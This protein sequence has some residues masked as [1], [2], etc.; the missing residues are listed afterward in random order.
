[1]KRVSL[2]LSLLLILSPF[3]LTTAEVQ[4]PNVVVE[5][6]P[7]LELFAIVYI[8]AFNGS[9]D[10]IIAPQEYIDAVLTY[11]APYKNH[12]AVYL[13]RETFPRELP[14]YIRDYSIIEWAAK[15]VIMP[16]L[17]NESEDDPLLSGLLKALV[18][19]AKESNFMRFYNSHVRE[20]KNA[21]RPA[22]EALKPKF[23]EK[24]DNL[25]GH[26]YDEYHISLSYSIWIHPGFARKEREVYYVGSVID[27]EDSGFSYTWIAVH[28]FSHGYIN[29]MVK[30]YAHEFSKVDYYFRYVKTSLA[31]AQYDRHF[32]ANEGY[33]SE[34]LVE[35]TAHYVIKNEYPENSKWGILKDHAL[36][37]YL[38][39]DLMREL[40]NFEETR[41]SNETFEEYI[42][43]LIEHMQRWATPENVSKYFWEKTPITS[44][45]ALDKSY[46]MGKLILVYSTNNPDESGNEYDKETAL[47]LKERLKKLTFW[48]FYSTKPV[49]VAKSDKELTD[50]DLKQNLIIIGGPGANEIA[51]KLNN[52]LPIKFVFNG[53]WKLER[54]ISNVKNFRAFLIKSAISREEISPNLKIPQNYPLGILQVIRNP[55]NKKN[56]IIVIAGVDRYSTRRITRKLVW[57]PIS[58]LIESGNYVKSGFY[59]QR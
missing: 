37:F 30:K 52:K 48:G 8:L 54:N 1:V 57:K 47:E 34:S 58:Y 55:W 15:V 10:F 53:T 43:T 31:F 23:L 17:G 7:N 14:Y 35:A 12:E 22:K 28:E 38:V 25:F 27:L 24:F 45:L 41:K 33:I 3:Q 49:I 51:R 39:E 26:Q 40:E 5:I 59:I 16:Y 11:F 6:N 19:F 20:Y 36:G 46:T 42:P 9:D 4:K 29:S 21:I 56:F 32:D 18:S 44:F 50:E 2:I 13:M